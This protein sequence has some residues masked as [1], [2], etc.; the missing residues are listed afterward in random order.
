MSSTR[1]PSQVDVG[2]ATSTSI[3]HPELSEHCPTNTDGVVSVTAM[4]LKN[5]LKLAAFPGPLLA[6]MPEESENLR[7]VVLDD[8]EGSITPMR[9][10]KGLFCAVVSKIPL[11]ES[12]LK[13]W[14]GEEG[15]QNEFNQN[16]SPI[17]YRVVKKCRGATVQT[18]DLRMVGGTVKG[19]DSVVE[20]RTTVWI[21]CTNACSRKRVVKYI[22]EELK[23]FKGNVERLGW[24]LEVRV[25]PDPVFTAAEYSVP[26]M[27]LTL[28]R[29]I[30]LRDN[31]EMYLNV[32]VSENISACGRY[33]CTTF[34]KDREVT[35]H[36]LSR[37]GG[38]IEL[39][40]KTLMITT[41]HPMLERFMSDLDISSSCSSQCEQ[42]VESDP[43]S[44]DD[45]SDD[46]CACDQSDLS[47]ASE[48]YQDLLGYKNPGTITRW[49]PIQL[50]G[51]INF[52]GLGRHSLMPQAS[53]GQTPQHPLGTDF[54]LFELIPEMINATNTYNNHGKYQTSVE[55]YSPEQCMKAGPV[56]I[57]M[58]DE[59]PGRGFLLPQASG[60]YVR[61]IMLETRKVELD[62][63][64]A[65]G[66]SGAWVVQGDRLRGMII[67][68]CDGEPFAH[69]IA[70]E[71]LVPD[72]LQSYPLGTEINLP[73]GSSTPLHRA[74]S[75][76]FVADVGLLLA[77]DDVDANSDN[78]DGRTPLSLAAAAGHKA[79]V[80]LLLAHHEVNTDSKDHRKRTPLSHAAENGHGA[81]VKLLLDT[82]RVDVDYQ[83]GNG[84]TPLSYAVEN[85][86]GAVVKLLLDT[87]VTL[88][89]R[90]PPPPVPSSDPYLITADNPSAPKPVAVHSLFEIAPSEALA[91]LIAEVE[92]LTRITGDDPPIPPPKS[93][94]IPHMSGI[95]A[96]KENIVRSYSDKN[97]AKLRKQAELE[98]KTLATKDPLK[99]DYNHGTPADLEVDSMRLKQHPGMM[100]PPPQSEPYIIVGAD[101]QPVNLQHSAI[102]RKF[103][104]KNEPPITINQ[105]LQR[106]HQFCPMSTAVYLATSL[107]IH[108]L[109]VEER[110]IPVTRR[111][112]HRLVL[113]GLRVAM[114]A[115]EDLSYPHAKM[116]KVGGVS[117]AELSRLEISFCVL[118]G[119]ELVVAMNISL[120]S[121][122]TKQWRNSTPPAYGSW[123]GLEM[124]LVTDPGARRAQRS[125]EAELLIAGVKAYC[126]LGTQRAFARETHVQL[127]V[128]PQAF[129]QLD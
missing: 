108:R 13:E 58:D 75:S 31:T 93:P 80:E 28:E 19:L 70:V 84:R 100:S 5:A 37:L 126:R 77:R 112:A 99:P 9:H 49:K 90:P 12:A 97:L 87:G 29:P 63:P 115:L 101:S 26:P 10:H 51:P 25:D 110:A 21:S 102:I 14:N 128:E 92:L 119:F 48:S 98:T 52:L 56:D 67:A 120:G 20:L 111:N 34:T 15:I 76:G 73:N 83:D 57:L 4:A 122:F 94:T 22:D 54:A 109:A 47:E 55:T 11:P 35:G 123:K 72:I 41:A 61:D 6:A 113:A 79:V 81:V 59:R 86:H 46:E 32:E 107:Y 116:A 64:L 42:S 60:I 23:S 43:E 103:Y 114:K 39:N 118:V 96:E 24:R 121:K 89:L 2:S 74:A 40:G 91:L 95:Q 124:S 18:P 85:G 129:V 88:P 17:R 8:G 125:A 117:E 50:G 71:K 65:R 16:L 30:K 104:S 82:G 3:S 1:P 27:N 127:D 33:L 7:Y 38:L 36:R 69:M 45:T 66:T 105:Y 106:L 62:K 44:D 53:G 78:R 68:A